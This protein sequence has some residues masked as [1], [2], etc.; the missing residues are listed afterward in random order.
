MFGSMHTYTSVLDRSL[1]AARAERTAVSVVG[2][3]PMGRALA[4]R[5]AEAGAEVRLGTRS[6][7]TVRCEA[8]PG[9]S[10]VTNKVVCCSVVVASW[11]RVSRCEDRPLPCTSCVP[12]CAAHWSVTPPCCRRP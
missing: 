9:V 7:D 2:T 8:P 10:I 6:L 11:R 3:G 1:D 12:C 5:L 4:A